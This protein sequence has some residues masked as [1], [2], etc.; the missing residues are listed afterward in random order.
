MWNF[1]P[2]NQEREAVPQKECPTVVV[3]VHPSKAAPRLVCASAA[4]HGGDLRCQVVF[5][6]TMHLYRDVQGCLSIRTAATFTLSWGHQQ[7]LHLLP[8]WGRGGG[9]LMS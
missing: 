3:W 2:T 7:Q 1:S 8:N 4:R 6:Y 9:T 5:Y